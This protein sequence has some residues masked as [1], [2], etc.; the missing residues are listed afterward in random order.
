MEMIPVVSS[1][2]EAIGYDKIDEILRVRFLNDS[3]Y[4]YHLVPEHHYQGLL[5]APSHG[6]Y[7]DTYIKKGG[8]RYTKRR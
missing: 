7:L 3:V 1:N 4:D 8:Y 5:N 2:L 6:R